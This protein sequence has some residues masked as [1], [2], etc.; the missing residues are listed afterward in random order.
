MD[1]LI[2][3]FLSAIENETRREILRMLT[4]DPSYAL[5]MSRRMGISQQAINKQLFF[6]QKAGLITL[7]GLVPSTEGPP[8]RVYRPTNFCTI[9]MD[10]SRNFINIKRYDLSNTG[11]EVAGEADAHIGKL[12][13]I[14]KKIDALMEER[15]AL[16]RKRDAIMAA[17]RSRI[18]AIYSNPM[19][20]DIALRYIETLDTAKVSERTGVPEEIVK[21]I[22]SDLQK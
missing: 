4:I 17:I 12:I 2:D 11:G 6:L 21:A 8:R 9:V 10:Y 3:Y 20:R 1:E 5:E 13:E 18:N 15:N 14:D 7:E 22:V 19:A 16:L